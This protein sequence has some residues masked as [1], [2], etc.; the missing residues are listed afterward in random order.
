MCVTYKDRQLCFYKCSFQRMREGATSHSRSTSQF[1]SVTIAV[2]VNL[3]S[4]PFSIDLI[5]RIKQWPTRYLKVGYKYV[6]VFI[7]V[8]TYPT[9]FIQHILRHKNM[10]NMEL[11]GILYTVCMLRMNSIHSIQLEWKWYW[12]WLVCSTFDS[13][14]TICTLGKLHGP[15]QPCPRV[16]KGELIC[17][18]LAAQW[19]NLQHW[20][21]VWNGKPSHTPPPPPRFSK[22]CCTP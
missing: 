10:Y 2:V 5:L 11:R 9:D 17:M 19:I 18:P 4:M 13:N 3:I 22:Q 6:H 12:A 16:L 7:I 20:W 14:R 8:R 21:T 1:C 15:T